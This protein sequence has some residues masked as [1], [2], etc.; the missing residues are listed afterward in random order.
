MILLPVMSSPGS[1]ANHLSQ[2][3]NLKRFAFCKFDCGCCRKG[4]AP[5]REK[6]NNLFRGGDIDDDSGKRKAPESNP[7]MRQPK[8]KIRG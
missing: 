7:F 5:L 2:Q 3:S 6:N 4:G 1:R 8:S